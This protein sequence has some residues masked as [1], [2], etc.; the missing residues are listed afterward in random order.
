MVLVGRRVCSCP[1]ISQLIDSRN[2]SGFSQLVPASACF[3]LGCSPILDIWRDAEADEHAT[4]HRHAHAG[5]L[6]GKSK[7][8]QGGAS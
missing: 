5:R 8:G 2:P 4:E 6:H 3:R 7:A 1:A